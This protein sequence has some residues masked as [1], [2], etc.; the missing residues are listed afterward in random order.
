MMSGSH[1]TDGLVAS[2]DGGVLLWVA[3][4]HGGLVAS[5]DRGV[6]P[7]VGGLLWVALRHGAGGREDG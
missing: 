7:R 1:H 4:R 2:G 6:L 5:G 3:L